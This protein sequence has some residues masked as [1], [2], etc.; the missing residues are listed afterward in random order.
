MLVEF[1]LMGGKVRVDFG[2]G[3][4]YDF[5]KTA[6][7]KDVVVQIR[8]TE[9][10]GTR[11]AEWIRLVE[12]DGDLC[13]YFFTEG[14]NEQIETQFQLWRGTA[15][16]EPDSI[17]PVRIDSGSMKDPY[18]TSPLSALL[19][20]Q[21]SGADQVCPKCEDWSAYCM[22]FGGRPGFY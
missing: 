12:I 18:G 22:C 4:L 3:R 16:A 10:P 5:Y 19:P 21:I 17:E 9:V 6:A 1:E 14:A 7:W 13:T 8:R 11:K 20:H 2:E 15:D